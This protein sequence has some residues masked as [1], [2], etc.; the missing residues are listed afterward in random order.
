M[1]AENCRKLA[2]TVAID[3]RYRIFAVVFFGIDLMVSIS[4]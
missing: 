4:H 1:T 2:G 3:R